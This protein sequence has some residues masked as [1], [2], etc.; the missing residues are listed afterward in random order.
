MKTQ[1]KDWEPLQTT[2][3]QNYYLQEEGEEI[4]DEAQSLKLWSSI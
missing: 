2:N 1:E 3:T 4:K